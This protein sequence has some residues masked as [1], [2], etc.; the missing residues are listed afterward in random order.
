MAGKDYSEAKKIS[1]KMEINS[2]LVGVITLIS[3]VIVGPVLFEFIGKSEITNFQFMGFFLIA[4]YI[5]YAMS[6]GP[7]Y[8]LYA[9]S[10]DR[11]LS[12]INLVG[13]FFF[14]LFLFWSHETKQLNY[15][16]FGMLF[17]MAL[18]YLLKRF[19]SSKLSFK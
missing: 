8:L 19:Y 3:Y 17:S 9:M 11:L 15:V 16:I 2:L 10:K 12:T 1:L 4:S 6:I 13:V 5:L 18:I 7:H 14:V